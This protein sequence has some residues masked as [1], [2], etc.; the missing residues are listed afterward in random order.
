M[1]ITDSG[2]RL[3]RWIGVLDELAAA[4]VVAD[5]GLADGVSSGGYEIHSITL[6]LALTVTHAYAR[7]FNRLIDYAI[8]LDMPGVRAQLQAVARYKD[9]VSDPQAMFDQMCL[10]KAA[11]A[12]SASQGAN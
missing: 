12:A 8:V 5:K 11:A 3:K 4:Q 10:E 6:E 2:Q 7:A 9:I 1:C